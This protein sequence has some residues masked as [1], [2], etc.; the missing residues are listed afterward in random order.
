MPGLLRSQRRFSSIASTRASRVAAGLVGPLPT[1]DHALGGELHFLKDTLPLGDLG[2]ART[3]SSC[4][5]KA[6][7]GGSFASAGARQALRRGG[8]S[9][10]RAWKRCIV[11]GSLRKL[12]SFQA[13]TFRRSA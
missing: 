6:C 7:E 2:A 8:R 11:S 13:A 4:R 9:P 3:R 10:V 1:L 5:A 12:I